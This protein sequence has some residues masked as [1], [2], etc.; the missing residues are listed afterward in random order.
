MCSYRVCAYMWCGY[1]PVVSC[2]LALKSPFCKSWHT[3]YLPVV[4]MCT[5]HWFSKLVSISV[6]KL[7]CVR[8]IF[9]SVCQ[10]CTGL[11]TIAYNS[12]CTALQ[13]HKCLW[14]DV[15]DS[16]QN[17]IMLCCCCVR[18]HCVSICFMPIRGLLLIPCCLSMVC[19][20]QGVGFQHIQPVPH[21]RAA[22]CQH[23]DEL[24]SS[25]QAA[26][27]PHPSLAGGAGLDHDLV[28]LCR[29]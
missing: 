17:P 16:V 1:I 2:L 8:R 26:M 22:H 28:P 21:D 12:N 10:Q 7:H 23:L 14:R 3:S 29:A 9:P 4:L 15:D 5:L 13:T 24:E 25:S 19:A 20:I 18:S 6:Y 11:L 27:G